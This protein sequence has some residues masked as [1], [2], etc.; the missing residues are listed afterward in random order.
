MA[1]ITSSDSGGERVPVTVE[2]Q[3]EI[4]L[5]GLLAELVSDALSLT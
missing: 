2:R 3:S 1:T 4:K 5:L